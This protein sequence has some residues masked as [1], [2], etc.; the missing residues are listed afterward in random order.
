MA[1]RIRFANHLIGVVI[2]R[3]GEDVFITRADDDNFIASVNVS[4]S[5]HFLGW[6]FGFGEEARILSPQTVVN[7]FCDYTA[8]VLEQYRKSMQNI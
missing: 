3:F 5:P 6:V 1:V 2:D 8:K 7:Q 4:I